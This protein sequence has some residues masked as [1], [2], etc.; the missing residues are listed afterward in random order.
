MIF[1]IHNDHESTKAKYI[2]FS[3]SKE[4]HYLPIDASVQA[5]NEHFQ[6]RQEK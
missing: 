5:P 1:N 3:F 4:R 2:E 6:L